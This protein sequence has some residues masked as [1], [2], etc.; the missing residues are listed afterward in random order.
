MSKKRKRSPI[1]SSRFGMGRRLATK[2]RVKADS[3]NHPFLPGAKPSD[4]LEWLMTLTPVPPM[5]FPILTLALRVA[6]TLVPTLA[7]IPR[8]PRLHFY[9]TRT[10][11]HHYYPGWP[12]HH[13]SRALQA[14][15]LIL[16][17]LIHLYY[18]LLMP[19]YSTAGTGCYI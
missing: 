5:P 19:P 17:H 12:F 10:G 11:F 4:L 15:K 6:L 8:I 18:Y 9:N 1:I 2:T 3:F 16:I 14:T 13:L 7:P